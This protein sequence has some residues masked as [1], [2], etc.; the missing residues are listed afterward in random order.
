[1]HSSLFPL[2]HIFDWFGMI[3]RSS[4]LS[5]PAY[6]CLVAAGIT[7][8]LRLKLPVDPDLFLS[9]MALT[10]QIFYF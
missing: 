2:P 7:G 3:N 1:M 9:D 5:V 6:L 8:T 10:Q 4:G